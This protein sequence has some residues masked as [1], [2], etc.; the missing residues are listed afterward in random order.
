MIASSINNP[1]RYLTCILAFLAFFILHSRASSAPTLWL[2]GDSTVKNGTKG[3]RGWGEEIGA[4][5]DSS[6]TKVEN[7]ALGG[8]SSR[9]YLSEGLWDK[10]LAQIKPGDFLLMQFG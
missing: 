5:F 4:Y 10:V 2:I 1:P 7:R 3:L 9:T 6:K 8:R